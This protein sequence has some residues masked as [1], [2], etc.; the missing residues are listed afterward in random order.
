[1]RLVGRWTIVVAVSITAWA[2]S[3]APA[4]AAPHTAPAVTSDEIREMTLCEALDRA[5]ELPRLVYLTKDRQACASGAASAARLLLCDAIYDRA[6]VLLASNGR[7]T[8]QRVVDACPK[9]SADAETA[10]K[11]VIAQL[12]RNQSVDF[13]ALSCPVLRYVGDYYQNKVDA[14]ITAIQSAGYNRINAAVQTA[15]S[16][17]C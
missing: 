10:G 12:K 5:A 11:Q 6:G 17:K 4:S 9:P 13:G 8:D 14:A 15:I 1:M 3:G 7:V 2:L 16:N